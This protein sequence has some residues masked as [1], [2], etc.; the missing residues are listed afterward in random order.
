M[1]HFQQIFNE[2]QV[3]IIQNFTVQQYELNAQHVCIC[4][5]KFIEL[6]NFTIV[7][8]DDAFNGDIAEDAFD[9]HKLER[10]HR[11]EERYLI[12]ITFIF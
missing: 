12:G 6:D 4:Y 2:K 3:F 10:I 1:N 7:F 11:V 8:K 9:F 5:N